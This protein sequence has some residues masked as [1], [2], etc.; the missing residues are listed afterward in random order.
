MLSVLCK[1]MWLRSFVLNFLLLSLPA[2]VC[3][4]R[5]PRVEQLYRSNKVRLRRFPD[6]MCAVP[7]T[8]GERCSCF[9]SWTSWK[10]YVWRR[11]WWWPILH[12]QPGSL[13]FF[14]FFFRVLSRLTYFIVA[15]KAILSQPLWKDWEAWRSCDLQIVFAFFS[16][17]TAFCCF[18]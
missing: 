14:L 1:V 18:Q 11:K 10:P 4:V 13:L 6:L 8:I 16:V 17:K 12:Q 5:D 7:Q 3:S 2:L 9:N 15:L